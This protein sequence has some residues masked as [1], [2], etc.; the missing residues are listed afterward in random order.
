MYFFLQRNIELFFP[1]DSYFGIHRKEVWFHLS[2][3]NSLVCQWEAREDGAESQRSFNTDSP[4][5]LV[6]IL[7]ILKEKTWV[8][9]I[10]L[11]TSVSLPLPPPSP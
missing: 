7:Y 4:C 8:L 9:T 11:E 3:Y 2:S 1:P 10:L 6:R 5:S